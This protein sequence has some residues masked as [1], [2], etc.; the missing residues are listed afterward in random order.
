VTER[1]EIL[2]I[3][4]DGV[5]ADIWAAS[6]EVFEEAVLKAYE[7]AKRI[8]WIELTAGEKAL[9]TEGE[10]LPESTLSGI[11]EGKVALKGPLTTPVGGGSS[12]RIR[13]IFT[14]ASSGKRAAKK[15]GAYSRF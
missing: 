11:R 13:K 2:Y 14:W 4:G 1:V 9:A 12:V 10:L 15:P 3:Q 6:H 7:G 8:E 5:G